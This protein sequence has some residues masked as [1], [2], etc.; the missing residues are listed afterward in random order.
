MT[1][2]FFFFGKCKKTSTGFPIVVLNKIKKNKITSTG[3]L[4]TSTGFSN[5]ENK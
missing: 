2:F 5:A 3:F 4:K 1:T